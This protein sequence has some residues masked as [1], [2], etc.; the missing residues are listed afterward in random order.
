MGY[1]RNRLHRRETGVFSTVPLRRIR[2]ARSN[3]SAAAVQWHG[4]AA[5]W[6][7][8]SVDTMLLAQSEK[9]QGLGTG[10]QEPPKIR[11]H[12]MIR[13]QYSRH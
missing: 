9:S 4:D 7:S 1:F 12:R 11:K 10:P 2:S 3:L 8:F 13:S 6:A 5:V